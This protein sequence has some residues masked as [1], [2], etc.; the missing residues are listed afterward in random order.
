MIKW[1]RW[2]IA[3]LPIAAGL[4]IASLVADATALS[5]PILYLRADLGSLAVI[6]GLL[7][8]LCIPPP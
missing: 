5:N 1:Q 6:V 4:V 7:L 3:L 2:A 8:L